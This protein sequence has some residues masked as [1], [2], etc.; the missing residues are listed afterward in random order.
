MQILPVCLVSFPRAPLYFVRVEMNVRSSCGRIRLLPLG[1][2]HYFVCKHFFIFSLITAH[3]IYCF[4]YVQKIRK[5]SMRKSFTFLRNPVLPL[6]E[7]G[8]LLVN[9]VI[10]SI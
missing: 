10:D 1:E 4:R 8:N 7:S 5:F 9:M 6:S 3:E 2:T